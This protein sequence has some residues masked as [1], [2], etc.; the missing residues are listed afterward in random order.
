MTAII[1]TT[2]ESPVA[3]SYGKPDRPKSPD[4]WTRLW[5]EL[6]RFGDLCFIQF[7]AVRTGWEWY[8]LVS[9]ITP[10][11]LLVFIRFLMPSAGGLDGLYY[12]AGNC[13]ITLAF[14]SMAT[15]S[16]QLSAFRQNK[17]FDYYAGLPVPR[18]GVILATVAVSTLFALPGMIL[19]VVLGALIFHITLHPN[20]LI[21]LV[22]LLAP[23][24]L[25][26]VGALIGVLA[27]NQ[28][29]AGTV[30]NL[31]L[32]LVMF[33][34]PVLVPESALPGV[35]RVTGA[36]LPPSYA[37]DALRRTLQGQLNS[38]VLLDLAFMALFIVGSI[39]LV[40]TRLDWRSR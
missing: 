16:G 24:T 3:T 38:S 1:D 36:L 18:T 6:D 37:A 23:L 31:A 11:G 27:P 29:V 14:S 5:R 2:P 7:A 9:S 39:Y 17:L 26:G 19:L 12:V 25:S 22:L 30:S 32:V 15:L 28:Q 33:L 21:V 35:L 4:G 40:T 10:V 13:V 20:V 34:S 8:F